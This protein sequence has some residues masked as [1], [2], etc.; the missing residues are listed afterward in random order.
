MRTLGPRAD[1]TSKSNPITTSPAVS[2]APTASP[3]PA[4]GTPKTQEARLLK[5]MQ[6]VESGP[7]RT[8]RDL[9]LEIHLSP[10]HLQ[11]LFKHET[12]VSMGEWLS[13]QRLRRAAHLLEKSYLSVKEI[14]H[15]VGY[16][17]PSS[18]IRAFERRFTQPPARYRKQ[19]T[20]RNAN[21][22]QVML[23]AF[24]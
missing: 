21:E 11:R 16:E 24:S 12:G 3:L 8:I 10:S 23:I 1:L 17:H 15:T 9:A 14:A 13:E 20:A 22:S 4:A 18:F 7:A 6:M 5:V 19:A 2:T